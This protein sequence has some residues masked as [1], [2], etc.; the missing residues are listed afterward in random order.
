[1]SANRKLQT[2]IDRTL[3]KVEEGVE[4]FDEVW[5]KVY[6]ATQQNQKEKY[7]VDLKKEIKKLQR[8]RDQIKTWAASSDVGRRA[9]TRAISVTLRAPEPRLSSAQV[10]DKR[11]LA[12]ARKL[13][14]TKMEQFKVCEKETKTKTYSKEGLA[15]EARVDPHEA[16]RRSTRAWLRDAADRLGAQVDAAEADVERLSAGRGAKKHRAEVEALEASVRRHKWHVARLE[17]IARLLDNSVLTPERVDE[18]REDVEYY[19]DANQE[20]DFADA[21]DETMDIFEGLELGAPREARDEGA[22]AR[23][24]GAPADDDDGLDAKARRKRDRALLKEREREEKRLARAAK[25]KPVQAV[26]L[27]IGRAVASKPPAPATPAP[28]PPAK[29]AAA[30]AAPAAPAKAPAAPAPA[31]PPA[32]AAPGGSSLAAILKQRTDRPAPRPAAPA[33]FAAAARQALPPGAAPAPPARRRGRR[34]RALR[35]RRPRGGGRAAGGRR[36]RGPPRAPR[37]GRRRWRRGGGGGGRAGD[38][39]RA[40]G[41]PRGGGGSRAGDGGGGRRAGAGAG[42]RRVLR[43]GR[44]ARAAPRP[45]GPRGRGRHVRA[46]PRRARAAA[47]AAG[48]RRG[49]GG[50][51]A[52]APRGGR[53]AAPRSARAVDAPRAAQ[54]RRR[55]AA[56]VRAAEP[57]RDARRLPDAAR[58]RLR[59]RGRLRAPRHGHALLRVLLPAGHVPAV[60]RRARAQ[61]AVLALPQ[62]VHDVVPASRGAQG[63]DGRLRA[64]HVRI[65]RLRDRLVPAH[66]VRLHLRIRV[67]RG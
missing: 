65:L 29:R 28:A 45:H 58:G 21:Y 64:G 49:L 44:L 62:E 4:V 11:A 36:R 16:A 17:Q 47:A 34:L 30:P 39:A 66:Q 6:S 25:A 35:G 5:D 50:R 8:H 51:P 63:H 27:T 60:P 32:A 42:R 2:E 33:P 22:V 61:E 37:T 7:E 46:P 43:A 19:I 24:G 13:I 41:A 40:R 38:R 3:K 18:V 52:R 20:P 57:L 26:P 14:E 53:G 55:A 31:A 48:R 67:P 54:A 1:M 59:R 23:G 12:T 15:R 10:K 9:A 56:A